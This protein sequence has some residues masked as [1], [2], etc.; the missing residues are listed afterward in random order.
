MKRAVSLRLICLFMLLLCGCGTDS[1]QIY[2]A[3]YAQGAADVRQELAS[4]ENTSWQEG[5]DA[6]LAE[7]SASEAQ[8]D[9]PEP[10][11]YAVS[12][13]T[14]TDSFSEG[15]SSG[16]R[17]LEKVSQAQY[18]AGYRDGIGYGLQRAIELIALAPAD[19]VLTAQP[20]LSRTLAQTQEEAPAAA[21]IPEA[22][23]T[24]AILS[25]SAAQQKT[26]SAAVP[27]GSDTVPAQ[28]DGTTVYI[29]ASGTK[30]HSE[31]CS[32]L[33]ASAQAVDRAAAEA[34]GYS[35]CSRCNP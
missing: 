35:A 3:G 27:T 31:G 14:R 16:L 26:D 1:A 10:S 21:V 2:Q 34:Q 13:D 30:Y 19:S 32:Y 29:T 15:Y 5:Y 25:A 8:N 12:A 22:P 17:D 7:L 6:A 33:S 18:E 24:E 23:V 4:E 20:D 28:S 11:T 9:E